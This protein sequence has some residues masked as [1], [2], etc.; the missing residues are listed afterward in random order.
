MK[1]TRI[2]LADDGG[3]WLIELTPQEAEWLMRALQRSYQTEPHPESM[4]ARVIEKIDAAL[5]D[6]QQREC[7]EPEKI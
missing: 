4:A 7:T 2:K 6:Q 3:E 5:F 1:T